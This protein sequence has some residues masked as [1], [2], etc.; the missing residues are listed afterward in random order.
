M[1]SSDILDEGKTHYELINELNADFF[2]K[3]KDTYPELSDSEVIVCY[4]LCIGFKNK[5][6]GTFLNR[7]TRSIESKRYRISKKIGL[8]KDTETLVEHLNTLFEAFNLPTEKNIS[9]L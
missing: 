5:E 7:S 6:I 8:S 4:Y 2:K 9:K 3:L 1:K